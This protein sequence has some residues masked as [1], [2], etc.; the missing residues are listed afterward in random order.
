[1][2]PAH[3]SLSLFQHPLAADTPDVSPRA[4]LCK[5]QPN[6][7]NLKVWLLSE[8][9]TNVPWS[10][11]IV[12]VELSANTIWYHFPTVL[13]NNQT[14]HCHIP[15]PSEPQKDHQQV[16]HGQRRWWVSTEHLWISTLICILMNS[17]YVWMSL[18]LWSFWWRRRIRLGNMSQCFVLLLWI[19]KINFIITSS[20]S[21]C[22]PFVSPSFFKGM[23][24]AKA[25][26]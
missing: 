3:L 17:L 14:G 26:T 9:N 6:W 18:L 8:I 5:F 24:M 11:P 13:P 20:S 16:H 2:W 23:M 15:R 19:P 21:F 1:M 12:I 10:H 22:H 25:M 4:F 7:V